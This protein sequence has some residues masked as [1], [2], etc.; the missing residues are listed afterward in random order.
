MKAFRPGTNAV[1]EDILDYARERR[2]THMGNAWRYKQV[3]R[4]RQN[5]RLS[6]R[7]AREWNRV[8]VRLS[9]P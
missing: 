6:V 8:V 3:G 7:Y 5:V 9:R 4:D 2:E 1:R